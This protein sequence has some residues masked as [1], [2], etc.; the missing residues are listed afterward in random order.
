MAVEAVAI[1]RVAQIGATLGEG[2]VWDS[3]K[4]WLWFVDIKKPR[5]YRYTEASG[6]IDH[7]DAPAEIGW[8][9]TCDD[10]RLLCGLQDGLYWFDPS[11]G[12][13]AF[14]CAVEPDDPD[15]RLNDATTDPAGRIWFGSMDNGEAKDS[16][17]FYKL[18]RDTPVPAGPD[19]ISITNGPAVSPDGKIIY[20][21]D[22][23]GR[24]I[25]K[26]SIDAAGNVGPT[27]LFHAFAEGVG[28]P[29][30]PVCDSE[31]NVWSCMYAGWG[32]RCFNPQGKQIDF[33]RLPVANV[34]K[35]AFG[36]PDLKTAYFTT[37]AQGLSMKER[38]EQPFAG[39]LFSC[40]MNIAGVATTP[41]KT[42]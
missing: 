32:A 38:A 33:I 8:A 23:L 14:R 18:D 19:R 39:D 7:W 21:T 41:F 34:T 17:R 4:A 16:G 31:G 27:D 26:A 6:A 36:G 40:R 25:L 9:L 1:K 30:G 15:N 22:T 5:L 12:T 42:K 13:F 28:Y 29:D 10:G 37:A 11:T 2:P 35:L 3:A 20:F 24:K